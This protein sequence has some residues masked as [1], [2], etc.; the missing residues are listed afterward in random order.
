MG[1][2]RTL[3]L[4]VAAGR[5][6]RIVTISQPTHAAMHS[7]GWVRGSPLHV[8]AEGVTHRQLLLAKRAHALGQGGCTVRILLH[9]GLSAKGVG[10]VGR[11]G[12]GSDSRDAESNKQVEQQR[13]SMH[14][15]L[16]P[17]CQEDRVQ[18]AQSDRSEPSCV[19]GVQ[20]SEQAPVR[21]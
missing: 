21:P 20:C 15:P 13:I 11:R 2:L 19:A 17:A 7:G 16:A 1:A 8:L 4:S 5:H 6:P 14:A 3:S 10:R 18:A 9:E 12:A